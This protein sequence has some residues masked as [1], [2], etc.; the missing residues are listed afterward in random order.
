M[1]DKVLTIDDNE[2]NNLLIYQALKG[3]YE[4]ERINNGSDALAKLRDED[5]DI[6]LLDVNMPEMNGYHVC[7][8]IRKLPIN[9]NVPVLFISALNTL[10]NHIKGYE[11]GGND[12]IEKPVMIDEL[13]HK[14][15]LAVA[16][17]KAVVNLDQQL[18]FA[19]D[20]A[21]TAMT[22]SGELGV[23]LGFMEASF[24]AEN[25][26]ALI[27]CLLE[28]I[29]QYQI[30]ACIRL[31]TGSEH[32]ESTDDM[33]KTSKLEQTLLDKGRHADRIIR[34]GKRV[35]FNTP[36]A[37]ILV[38]NLPIDDEDKCGRLVDHLAAI[39][40]AAD[41]RSLQIE[42]QQKR[43]SVKNQV[44]DSVVE[45]ADQEIIKIQSQFGEFI[46]ETQRIMSQL[47]GDIEEA[48]FDFKLSTEQ[49]DHF[50]QLI[51]QGKRELSDL[52]DWGV[53]VEESLLKI[54]RSVSGSIEQMD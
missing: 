33:L 42:E 40:V 32:F 19:T 22:N 14:I 48:L 4:V 53:L 2:S 43:L 30:N 3:D 28:S 31:S 39:V 23:V 21:M 17:S 1:T 8:E 41:A 45:I 26:H 11:A 51:E 12:Y 13:K 29:R 47:H 5:F 7:K 20:T 24:K 25:E 49:E 44:L 15:Q 46:D 16:S 50:Y 38:R 9:N 6:V 27:Q 35:L 37:S 34:L 36:R 18:K 10:Q 54:R 52:S